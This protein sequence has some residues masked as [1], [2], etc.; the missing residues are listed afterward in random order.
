[1][2]LVEHFIA[3]S[4]IDG[5]GVFASRVIAL[6]EVAWIFHPL[7]DIEI[8]EAELDGLPEHVV[9]RIRRHGEYYVDRSTFILSADGNAFMNHSDNPNLEDLGDQLVARREILFGEELT[10]DYRVTPVLDFD[11]DRKFHVNLNCDF[12]AIK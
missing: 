11:P 8:H 12:G 5:F 3:P 6:G 4:E 2:L 10:C 9:N 7:I 1:M